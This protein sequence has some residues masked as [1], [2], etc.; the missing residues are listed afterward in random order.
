MFGPDYTAGCPACSAI[1]DGF[2]GFVVHLAHHDAALWAVSLAPLAK[3]QGYKRRMGWSFPW[4][5]SGGSDFNYDFNVSFTEEQQRRGDVQYNYRKGSVSSRANEIAASEAAPEAGAK[6]AAA[7]GTDWAA[8]TRQTAGLSAFVRE[9]GV[10]YHTYSTYER[11][12]ALG[13]VP[14]TRPGAT[15]A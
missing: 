4:A 3:L 5:S 15:R 7:V 2:N 9:D 10:V 8:Y 6:I 13:H 14:V 12:R 1:A 11:G